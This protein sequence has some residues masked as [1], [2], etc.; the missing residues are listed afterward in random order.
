MFSSFAL[1]ATICFVAGT[2]IVI[3]LAARAGADGSVARV[4]STRNIPGRRCEPVRITGV[5]VAVRSVR[6][7]CVT[8]HAR[9]KFRRLRC[10]VCRSK[11]LTTTGKKVTATSYWRCLK[12]GEIWNQERLGVG[13]RYAPRPR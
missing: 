4:L 5:A 9:K 13:A 8:A 6:H 1:A 10:P 3:A 11:D 12:C 2:L 7:A